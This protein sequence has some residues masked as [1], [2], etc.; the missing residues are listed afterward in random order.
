VRTFFFN[1]VEFGEEFCAQRA[2]FFDIGTDVGVEGAAFAG[3]AAV[4]EGVAVA[5]GRA[6]AAALPQGGREAL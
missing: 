5:S 4:L 3:V 1:S 2:A 6:A